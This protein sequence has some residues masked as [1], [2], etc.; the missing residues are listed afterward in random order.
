MWRSAS[1]ASRAASVRAFSRA[2]ARALGTVSVARG[3]NSGRCQPPSR[4]QRQM[5]ARRDAGLRRDLGVGQHGLPSTRLRTAATVASVCGRR[6]PRL[7][8]PTTA[9]D[10]P[11]AR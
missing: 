10:R 7:R 9:R 4:V 3:A 2:P 11:A 1:A 5:L 8:G 6:E